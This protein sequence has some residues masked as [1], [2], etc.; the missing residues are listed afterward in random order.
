MRTD[1]RQPDAVLLVGGKGARLQSIVTDRPKPMALVAGKPFVEWVLLALR[2]QGVRRI[3]FCTGYM[4]EVIEAHFRDGKQWDMEILYSRDPF[5]LGTAGAVRKSL[6]LVRSDRF[7]AINGDSYCRLDVNQLVGAHTSHGA[8]VTLWLRWVNDCRGYG[9]VTI[10][11]DGVV[12]EFQEKPLEKRPGLINA[13]IYLLDRKAAEGIPEGRAVSIETEFFPMLIGHGLYAVV[14]HAPFIDVGTP[15]G[16]EA[17]K[18]FFAAKHDDHASMPQSA[19]S[20]R[21]DRQS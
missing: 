14:G 1:S 10:A 9:L 18:Q 15:E 11:E 8:L 19:Q 17:A 3:I 20:P 21:H 5:P 7:L 12:R 16:F 6:G 13:G 4:S 2:A